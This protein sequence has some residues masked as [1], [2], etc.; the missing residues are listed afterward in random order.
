VIA[1][2]GCW[3]PDDRHK[4]FL[5]ADLG[6]QQWVAVLHANVLVSAHKIR[7]DTPR[8]DL[9]LEQNKCVMLDSGIFW[10]TNEHKR[11]HGLTMNDALAL[12][13]EDID[14][15]DELWD[16]Y[17]R[18]A[19]RYA[20]EWWGYVE[21][22][23]GG[24]ARKRETRRRLHDLGLRPIPVYHP[25]NDGWDYFDELASEHDRICFGNIVQADRATRVRLLATLAERK[26]AYPDLFVH[27]L[28]LTPN[29]FINAFPVD[30]ADSS[31]WLNIV[32]W[33]G[34]H[35]RGMLKPLGNMDHDYQYL[36]GDNDE[37]SPT[38]DKRAVAMAAVGAACHE[39]GWRHWIDRC[40][41]VGIPA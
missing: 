38:N 28:G 2:G 27:V 20:T 18:L 37:T 34:Y 32:R 29:E 1:T 23:Q 35:E 5:A 41:E 30:S 4:Y 31:T 22:D 26:R 12:A 19:K 10:L 9:L 39:R 14:G 3:D 13:P 40:A 33:D 7:E 16:R 6:R 24:A 36:V 21:L 15:F 25:L 11:A 8:V 17:V